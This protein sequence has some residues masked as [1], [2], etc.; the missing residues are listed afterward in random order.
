MK[1]FL[2]ILPWL[3][4]ESLSEILEELAYFGSQNRP[5][6]L[7]IFVARISATKTVKSTS[8]VGLRLVSDEDKFIGLT[9]FDMAIENSGGL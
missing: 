2:N 3:R 7:C 6:A 9:W 8:T 4:L 1:A 5:V